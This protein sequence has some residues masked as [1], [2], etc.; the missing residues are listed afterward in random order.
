MP[1]QARSTSSP[2]RLADYRRKRDFDLTP[3]PRD[4]RTPR[5]RGALRY[6]IQLHH[7]RSRHF[8]FRLELDGT[9]RSWAVPKGPSRDPAQKRLAVEVEDHP[10]PYAKFEGDIPQ[11]QYGAGHVD[12]WDEGYWE[13][14]GDAAAALKKGHLHFTLQGARLRGRWSLVRTRL[15]G[16]QPQWLLIKGQ[17]DFC[18]A[19]DVAS[20]VTRQ[21]FKA[22][23]APRGRSR[24]A[25]RKP[26]SRAQAHRRRQLPEP[27]PEQVELQLARLSDKAPAGRDWLHEIKYDGYRVLVFRDGRKLRIVSRNGIDW[28]EKLP[29]LRE[30]VLGLDCRRCILDGELVAFDEQGHS[31]FDLLQQ[32]FG[33]S[34]DTAAVMFDLLY[35]DSEDLR[36]EPL[37]TRQQA[38]Q[39]LLEAAPPVLQ[40]SQVFEGAG[41]EAFE[42]A[43]RLGLEGIVCKAREAP[44]EGGR[45]GN[46]LKVKCVQS[47][48]FVVVGYT[49]GQGARAALGSLLLARPGPA[50]APWQYV[51]RV[52]TGF[53]E[54]LI[55]DLLKGFRPLKRAPALDRGPGRA[56]LRGATPVW[57]KPERVI[58]VEFRAWTDD[59]LL[60]QASFKGLRPDKSPA[61]VARP[62]APPRL[63]AAA[64]GSRSGA[65]RR[66]SSAPASKKEAEAA[67][68]FAF[69]HPERQLFADPPLS[70]AEIGALYRDLADHILPGIVARPLALLRC[71][72]GI[73]QPCFFQKH[74]TPGFPKS[75]HAAAAKSARDP[76]V[77]IED[78]DGLLGLVQMNVI[79][80]HPWGAPLRD[81][82]RPDRIV[83]DLDPGP[84]V[85][86]SRVVAAARELRQRLDAL[87]L[88]SFPRVSGGKG[89]HVVVPLSGRD[90]WEAVKGFAQA[91][92]RVMTQDA[93]ERYIDVATKSRRERRIFID[94]LRNSRGATAIASYSLRARPGAPIAVPVHWDELARLRGPAPFAADNI[95]KRVA[96][97]PEPWPGF[98]EVRQA[99]PKAKR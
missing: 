52:G 21:E 67:A 42:A 39:R 23:A 16:R 50:G 94:Y 61:D 53:S 12:I 72:Q 17:D 11:G 8:D 81:P 28:T 80:I 70:K 55:G 3:E 5:P 31:R 73:G 29:A 76:Y 98:A 49:P 86:W 40:R 90:S 62:D 92:A 71:P 69:T 74:L 85:P 34:G 6:V 78:L 41:P 2:R 99:L 56:E 13:P 93:P 20:D 19:G 38:L 77:Y 18:E 25:A 43:C 68:P 47:D 63:R 84:A 87:K 10:I 91:M 46:W 36:G 83:F 33:H 4:Q 26:A 82:Q 96:A 9:L 65:A 37:R 95:R 44:Y 7:A 79:E 32:R 66:R 59:G 88:L 24:T 22:Q 58:E 54:A 60:R 48:E 89:L 15:G 97:H 35:L 45:G 30:A 75:V 27:F 64:G 14:E 51:G 57:V 1:R